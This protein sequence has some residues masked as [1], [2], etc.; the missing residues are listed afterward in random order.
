MYCYIYIYRYLKTL[1]NDLK[2]M[3]TPQIQLKRAI[4][5]INMTLVMFRFFR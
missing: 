2:D 4:N 3:S 1:V 5:S